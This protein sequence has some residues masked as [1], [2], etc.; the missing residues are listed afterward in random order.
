MTQRRGLA[1]G[2]LFDVQFGL[3]SKKAELVFLEAQ[4]AKPEA[5]VVTRD[6]LDDEMSRD[7]LFKDQFLELRKVEAALRDADATAT[8]EFK[9]KAGAPYRRKRQQLLEALD[10][11]REQYKPRLAAR[12]RAKLL[13]EYRVQVQRVRVQVQQALE[14]EKDLTER[15][16][17]L[18]KKEEELRAKEPKAEVKAI[19]DQVTQ[20]ENDLKK[21]GDEIAGLKAELPDE[22]EPGKPAEAAPVASARVNLLEPAEPPAARRYDKQIKAAAL[23]GGALF[24]LVLIGFFVGEVRARRVYSATDVSDGLGLNLIGTL[25]AVPASARKASAADGGSSPNQGVLHEAVDSIR[26]MLLHSSQQDELRVVLVTS[27]VGGEGKTSLASHLAASLARAWH[28]TLLLDADLREP[29]AHR[30]FDLP[31]EPGFSEVLRGDLEIAQAVQPT[32]V[33]RLWLMAAGRCDGHA[34]QALAQENVGQLFERLKEQFDFIILDACPVLPVADA[35][36]VGQHAD[37]ALLAVMR[38][39]S[40]IPEVHA[41]QQKLQ[42]LDIHM[43]GAVVIGEKAETYG[44]GYR[45]LPPVTK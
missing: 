21:L 34:L 41:A 32:A 11:L 36:L 38:D 22:P 24:A 9:E 1:E 26:T 12:V 31:P 3:K 19:Q 43:L 17:L 8:P 16:V 2:K 23:T 42:S 4:L 27:A 44:R 35:L 5:V 14:E 7:E 25:P 18:R 39:V 40:R 29:A 30:Q 20:T 33:S 6:Q 10:K 15:V 45:A 37:A 28:K 13:D